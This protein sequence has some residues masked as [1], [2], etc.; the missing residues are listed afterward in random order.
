MKNS[1]LDISAA[2]RSAFLGTEFYTEIYVKVD[3][4][5][6]LGKRIFIYVPRGDKGDATADRLKNIWEEWEFYHKFVLQCRDNSQ[7]LFARV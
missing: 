7:T 1:L 2:H 6:N 4:L 5:T 3:E